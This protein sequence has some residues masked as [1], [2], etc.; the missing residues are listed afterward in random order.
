MA[1]GFGTTG[2]VARTGRVGGIG[3]IGRIGALGRPRRRGSVGAASRTDYTS[4]GVTTFTAPRAGD[5]DFYLIGPGGPGGVS[6]GSA[7]SDGGGGG[8]AKRR[9]TLAKN[10]VAD[11]EVGT[12]AI[13]AN[14][15]TSV[16]VRGVTVTASQGAPGAAGYEEGGTGG[17][18]ANGDIN[19][20]GGKGSG[21]TNPDGDPNTNDG[22]EA[23][24][25]GDGNPLSG[26]FN[27]GTAAAFPDDLPGLSLSTGRG[28]IGQAFSAPVDPGD[29][30]AI[31]VI[32]PF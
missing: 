21:P 13:F 14:H 27:Y 8:G 19:L 9:F 6:P 5:Y 11:L 16:T 28:G 18:G 15:P 30:G 17:V 2:P 26:A 12:Y 29:D 32:G 3:H 1:G 4:A 20:H 22:I 24:T 31:V 10:E 7:A 25:H 23:G